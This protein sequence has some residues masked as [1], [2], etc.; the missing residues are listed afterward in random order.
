MAQSLR[1]SALRAPC[2]SA[3]LLL[4]RLRPLG[5]ASPPAGAQDARSQHQE[6]LEAMAQGIGP[7]SARIGPN[8]VIVRPTPSRLASGGRGTPA[9][10][11][12]P[13]PGFRIIMIFTIFQP[14]WARPLPAPP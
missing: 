11:I 3:R 9:Q 4:G 8:A 1:H 10:D 14:D 12:S 5:S 6:L 7:C 2:A 13:G